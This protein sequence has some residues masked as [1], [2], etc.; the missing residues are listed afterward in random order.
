MNVRDADAL[1]LKWFSTASVTAYAAPGASAATTSAGTRRR[2]R[3]ESA[4]CS[5][6]SH[7]ANASRPGADDAPTE[8]LAHTGARPPTPNV[9]DA[10]STSGTHGF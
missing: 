6:A 1:T 3:I 8:K 2:R 4:A 7:A 5:A 10:S 9:A